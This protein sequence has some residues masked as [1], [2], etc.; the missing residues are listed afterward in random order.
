MLF[1][2]CLSILTQVFYLS[3]AVIT[4]RLL[5]ISTFFLPEEKTKHVAGT[6]AFRSKRTQCFSIVRS[7]WKQSGA[8]PGS[9][10]RRAKWLKG[11]LW[12]V[13]SQQYQQAG[14]RVVVMNHTALLCWNWK[15]LIWWV[16]IWLKAK[17]PHITLNYR[18]ITHYK[19]FYFMKRN[20][21]FDGE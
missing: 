19:G 13:S 20:L 16:K 21:N 17:L 14:T 15:L 10:H 1:S 6:K 18:L 5:L 3:A 7:R 4:A 11:L 9:V 12:P 8:E 2:E